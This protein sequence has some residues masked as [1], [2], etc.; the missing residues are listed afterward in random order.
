MAYDTH[1]V[2]FLN[3]MFFRTPTMPVHKKEDTG[4]DN[5]DSVQQDKRG[6]T[7]TANFVTDDDNAAT[8]E[9]VDSSVPDTH[10]VNNNQG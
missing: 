10:M 4:D 7:I 2:V 1:D 8:V 9:S 6:G 5:L 3:R